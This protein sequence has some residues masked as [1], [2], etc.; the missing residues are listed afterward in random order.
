MGPDPNR[1]VDIDLENYHTFEE[2]QDYILQLE[3]GK[4]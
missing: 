2:I 4:R 3:G 1:A